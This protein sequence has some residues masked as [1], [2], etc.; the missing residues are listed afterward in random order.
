ML[1][2]HRLYNITINEPVVYMV[3]YEVVL[4]GP[5]P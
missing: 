1:A 3:L 2:R 5:N 4:R